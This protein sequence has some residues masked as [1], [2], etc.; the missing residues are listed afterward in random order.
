MDLVVEAC[1]KLLRHYRLVVEG[2]GRGS[3]NG[4]RLSRSEMDHV[5]PVQGRRYAVR[6]S[7]SVVCRLCTESTGTQD[8]VDVGTELQRWLSVDGTARPLK[9]GSVKPSGNCQ[10]DGSPM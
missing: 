5:V 6:C 3:Q 9:N 4:R 10:S 2:R 1:E 7:S 8:C